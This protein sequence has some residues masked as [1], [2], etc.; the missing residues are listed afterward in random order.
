MLVAGHAQQ[1]ADPNEGS[2]GEVCHELDPRIRA[3]RYL[4]R[5]PADDR[6]LHLVRYSSLSVLNPVRTIQYR[7][8]NH[9]DAICDTMFGT[10]DKGT[11][12]PQM[13]AVLTSTLAHQMKYA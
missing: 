13:V 8:R 9:G 2:C 11:V 4:A 5:A 6:V 7:A 1:S 12:N 10:G 3:G